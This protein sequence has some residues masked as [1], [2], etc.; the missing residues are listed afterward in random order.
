MNILFL[1]VPALLACTKTAEPAKAGP[2]KPAKSVFIQVD[3][4]SDISLNLSRTGYFVVGDGG[5]LHEVDL[6][7][8]LVRTAAYTGQ[9]FEG[10]LTLSNEHILV[11]EERTRKVLDFDAHFQKTA[12]H[13]TKLGGAANSGF[14]S[15]V[16]ND[17]RQKWGLFSE[18][19]PAQYVEYNTHWE[20]T[21]RQT[22]AGISEVS[23][24]TYHNNH[25]Y[26]L[27]DENHTLYL[28]DPT[29]LAVKGKWELDVYNPEG[30][31]FSPNDQLV[32]VSDDLGKMFW[33]DLPAEAK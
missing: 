26:V 19:N 13:T 22:I 7:G 20:E 10:V 24:M 33:F 14:E 28:L 8:K 15:I 9:D 32:V 12:E 31:A 6:E 4:P 1:L 29:T 21:G 2:L 25:L 11:V 5:T 16:W 18:K 23:S 3:E 27:G 30:I 17:G